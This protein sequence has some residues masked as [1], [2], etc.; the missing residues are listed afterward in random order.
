MFR[1]KRYLTLCSGLYM[2]L[3]GLFLA[4]LATPV[5]ASAQTSQ[6]INYNPRQL[7]TQKIMRAFRENYSDLTLIS[8]H[9]GVHALAQLN[10][11]PNVPENS[12]EAIEWAAR[13]GYEA[14][15]VD[16]RLTSDGQAVLTHDKSWGREWCGSSNTWTNVQLFDP[17]SPNTG[18]NAK[19]NPVVVDTPYSYVSRPRYGT[20]LRDSVSLVTDTTDH[21]CTLRN[22]LWGEWPPTLG[23]VYADIRSKGIKAVLMIDVQSPDAALAAWNV[24]Q[25]NKDSDGNEAYQSTIFKLPADMFPNHEIDFLNVFQINYYDSNNIHWIPVITTRYVAPTA[26]PATLNPEDGGVD[27]SAVTNYGFGSETNINKW[28]DAMVDAGA[29]DHSGQIMAVEVVMKE[30]QGILSN[31]L[32]HVGAMKN[33]FG[34]PM[35]VGNFHPA[36]EYYP[37]GATQ[38]PQYFRSSDGTCCDYLEAYLYNNPISNNGVTDPGGPQ[39]NSDIRRSFP[40]LF[41]TG[42]MRTSLVTTDDPFDAAQYLDRLRNQR[43]WKGHLVANGV[44]IANDAVVL[45]LSTLEQSVNT[46][47]VVHLLAGLSDE[48]ATGSVTFMDG[49]T[50]LATVPLTGQSAAYD[51]TET[52][53]GDHSYIAMYSGDST[54]LATY[55]NSLPVVVS[56]GNTSMPS[57]STCDIYASGGTPCV[58]A[59]STVR[60]LFGG[61]GGRL[62]QVQR[63][64]DGTTTDIGTLATGGYANAAAQD[65]FCASTTCTITMIYD[66]TSQHNDLAIE[67][68]GGAVQ[69]PDSGAVANALPISVNGNAV[70][71]VKVTP[72][73]GYRNNATSGVAKGASPEGMYMV[74]SGTFVN[75]GCCFDY[76][77][78]E[79]NS[80]DN[81]EGHMDALNFG[82]WCGFTCSG[83]GPWVEADLENGQYMG[84][85]TNLGDVSMGYDFVTAMLK[86]DGQSTFALKGG[87]AQ[88]GGLTTDYSGSLPTTKPGYIPMKLEGAIVLGTGGDNSNWGQGAFFEGAMTSGYPTDATETAVQTNIVAA[89]YTGDSSGGSAGSGG[90]ASTDPAGTYTGPSDPGGSGPQDGFASPATEQPDV[91]MGS[92]PALASFNGRLY[93]AF[94]AND[95]SHELYVTS[96]SSGYDLPSVSG[97]GYA[98][99]QMG[100]APAMAEFN[101]QLFVAFQANDAGHELYVT[102]SSSGNYFPSVNGQGHANILMGGAPALAVFNNQLCASFQADDAS[103]LLYV[104]CSPDG[105]TWPTARQIP[106]VWLGSDP[107][108]ATFNGKLYV[109]YRSNDS[110][111]N[112]WIASSSDGVNFSNQMLGQTMG[113]S[114]SPALVVSNGVLY[115]IHEANDQG[116]E[117]LVSASTDGSTW[118]GPAA[119]LDVKM[120]AT[121]PGAAA[122][123]NGVYVGFQSNDSRNVLYV[124]NKVT[125][126]AS[127]TGPSDPNGSGPQDGLASPATEQPNDI[128]ATK[129]ALAA[130]NGKLYVAFQGVNVQ[131]DLYVASSTGNSFPTATQYTN[132]QSSSA[133]ALAA[134]NNKLFM[135]FRGLNVDNDFYITSSQTGDNFPTATRYTN[136]QM[137]GAPALATFNSQLCAAFQAND[138][139]NHLHVT[140]SSDGVTW[141]TAPEISNVWTGSDPAMASFNGKLYI[142]YRA[143]DSSN[144]VWIASSSDGVDF[145][146]QM[147]GQTMGGSSSP[148]L[149][150]SNC[151]LYLIYG[152][153]DQNNEMMVMSSPDGSNWQ[154]PKAYL[155]VKMGATGPGAAAFA[156]GVS[157]GF[158]SNDARNVLFVTNGADGTA[159]SSGSCQMGTLSTGTLLSSSASYPRVVRLSYG[160]SSVNGQIIASIN[161]WV[162]GSSTD[163]NGK[164]FVSTDGGN[165]FTYR[166]TV[167]TISGSIE[168]CCATLFEL[169][170]TV[171]TF[172]AGTLLF[173]ATYYHKSDPY[174]AIE[175][176]ASTDQGASWH[177]VTTPVSGGNVNGGGGLWEPAFEIANDGE[178]VMFWSDESDSCCSQKIAQIRSSDVIY[179]GDQTNTV[180]SRA[181][182]DRPGMA[183]VTKLP[184]GLFFMSYEICGPAGCT[185]YSRTSTDGWNFGDSTDVG[186]RVAT[187]SG[188]YFE[189]A[190]TNVWA[191]QENLLHGE[192]LLIGQVMLESNNQVSAQNGETIFASWV[193]DNGI[194]PWIT[195]QSPIQVPDARDNSCPNYSSALLPSLDGRSVLELASDYNNLGQ[196][197]TYFATGGII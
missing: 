21:G 128:M 58:A 73:V 100:G 115:Y 184:N 13:D 174:V 88:S 96:S 95:P 70:Y 2:L 8:A 152:A 1:N 74:T 167:P 98:N 170:K 97:Q 51:V 147:L 31:V 60:A 162:P 169:P 123:G 191:P 16:V 127:Y 173:A 176:Y 5:D 107:A 125:E 84:N 189:H 139:S 141:P 57:P 56:S 14:I 40:F 164:I 104:T 119:Y 178:L 142:A 27:V 101:H 59:H 85:G 99:I 120:G 82:T 25:A 197:E 91:F 185:V 116:H 62:Y 90:T 92:R 145:S 52:T 19:A 196:C 143:N 156:H 54:F 37:F 103:H 154:G 151:T 155:D 75:K 18:N 161:D 72:G 149:V 47:D 105:V 181:H 24:V 159:F 76:G 34:F 53:P 129:P 106:N 42:V 121:G 69:S 193:T 89:G 22:A 50:T 114:S 28:V 130:F 179:W 77:N 46:G 148:A 87:N 165:T 153:N 171:G 135:A 111:R 17:F 195:I 23:Q 146:N 81:G 118:Q 131:N 187:A 150:V 124:T 55:S 38:E 192:I 117:M 113:G 94:Q 20:T 163:L 43:N 86:N 41:R 160:S 83:N 33:Q 190:P 122:F 4:G 132:L 6:A 102:S 49:G 61:Y 39:D 45:S 26:S 12:L 133:P 78:V 36:G 63:A 112:A 182:A 137:G 93:V 140:C 110:S 7:D 144:N 66:Q 30:S 166:A 126:A 175:V 68:G 71:G 44:T 108:M 158:Q 109:A 10:Q 64:S 3:V 67:G 9:R 136:I 79:T 194:S 11:V 157:V 32:A 35:M 172:P 186:T 15:E 180:A 134:F 80:G 65:S 177:Y 168:K 48:S 188:Q 138:P 29:Q 183:T